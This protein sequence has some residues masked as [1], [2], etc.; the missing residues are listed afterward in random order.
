[1]DES[2]VQQTENIFKDSHTTADAGAGQ[3]GL[4]FPPLKRGSDNDEKHEE[5]GFQAFVLGYN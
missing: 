5:E 4:T 1:M 2:K 3:R